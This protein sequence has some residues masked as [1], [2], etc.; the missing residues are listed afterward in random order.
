[1]KS[2][3]GNRILDAKWEMHKMKYF[4]T[5]IEI[6]GIDRKGMLRDLADVISD[7]FSINIR[8]ITVS[9]TDGV[10][11]GRIELG[12]HDREELETLI[13]QLKKIDDMQEA[14]QV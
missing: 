1:L 13:N 11:E 12:V 14:V 4:D 5:T 10:F 6:H 7:Q 3:F 2:S 8:K 9:A